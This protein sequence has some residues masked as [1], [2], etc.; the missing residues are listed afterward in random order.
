MPTMPVRLKDH[1]RLDQ[2]LPLSLTAMFIV[3]FC[4]LFI[5]FFFWGCG[6]P[7]QPQ[8]VQMPER[9][10]A[11]RLVF[12]QKS[13]KPAPAFPVAA[14]QNKRTRTD[15]AAEKS[16]LAFPNPMPAEQRTGQDGIYLPDASAAK[17]QP[18]PTE[19][20]SAAADGQNLQN[21]EADWNQRCYQF[22]EN[23]ESL[24]DF[25]RPRR[26]TSLPM[27]FR[28]TGIPQSGEIRRR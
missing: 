16:P 10:A 1:L 20:D 21:N 24:P 3:A 11:D 15:I 18:G 22:P 26:E 5:V 23:S 6:A 19:Q 9:P 17:R 8:T 13:V 25:C 27:I 2:R 12:P 14:P 7:P 4:L 28:E